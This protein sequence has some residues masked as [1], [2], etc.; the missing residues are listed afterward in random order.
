[1]MYFDLGN[2]N[3]INTFLSWIIFAQ[4]VYH[5][6]ESTQKDLS[7]RR[8]LAILLYLPDSSCTSTENFSLLKLYNAF[9]KESTELIHCSDF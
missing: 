2:V 1:M 3:Q 8:V 9:N 4:S 6:I 5:T 7:L